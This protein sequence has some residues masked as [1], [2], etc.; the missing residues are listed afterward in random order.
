MCND[1]LEHRFISGEEKELEEVINIFGA[2]LLRYA[3]AILCDYH[4][5]VFEKENTGL[6]YKELSSF[7]GK[8]KATLRK[9]YERAKKISEASYLNKK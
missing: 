5:A 9:Q 7:M 4:E 8:S 1:D 6:S 3:T 2:K